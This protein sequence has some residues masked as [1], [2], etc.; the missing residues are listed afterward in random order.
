M[1]CDISGSV[2]IQSYYYFIKKS[3]MH[4]FMSSQIYGYA[5]NMTLKSVH[6]TWRI[7]RFISLHYFVAFRCTAFF[8]AF[9]CDVWVCALHVLARVVKFT[10]S[11][12][13]YSSSSSGIA[14]NHH[15]AAAAGAGCS[16]TGDPYHGKHLKPLK[17][18]PILAPK[19]FLWSTKGFLSRQLNKNWISKH[20]TIVKLSQFG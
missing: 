3:V 1:Q 9:V 2:W 8:V 18:A 5:V 13:H 15:A 17:M 6:T 11:F 12:W 19:V 7:T 16:I 14:G 20:N 10:L 4:V